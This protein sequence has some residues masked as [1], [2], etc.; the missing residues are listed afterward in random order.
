M[1]DYKQR[2]VNEY[3]ELKGKYNNLHG[4]L[5]RYDAGKLD[6]MPT[7][8]IGLLRE[9]AGIMGKYLYILEER[10]IIEDIDIFGASKD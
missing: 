6:F 2:M 10:A 9:Q 4:M 3:W 1:E 8:P 7:C 5:V